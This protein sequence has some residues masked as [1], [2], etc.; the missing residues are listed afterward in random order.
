MKMLL[1]THQKKAD[2]TTEGCKPPCGFSELIS[3]P[4]EEQPWYLEMYK[5]LLKSRKG[6]KVGLQRIK[7]DVSINYKK[8]NQ[9]KA[10]RK[11]TRWKEENQESNWV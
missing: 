10:R 4:L 1:L 11:F 9:A 2:L 5:M 6:Y 3:G 7:K 8:E